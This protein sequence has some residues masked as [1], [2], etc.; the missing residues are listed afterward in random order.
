MANPPV[1]G[2]DDGSKQY[3]VEGTSDNATGVRGIAGDYIYRIFR[4]PPP[5]PTKAGVWGEHLQ[6]GTGVLGES[7]EGAGVKGL[8]GNNDGVYGQSDAKQAIGV[9]GV[10]PASGA[11]GVKGENTSGAGIGVLGRCDNNYGVQGLG[12]VGV[13]GQ[14]T[15]IGVWAV[16][17]D[18]CDGLYATTQ[19]PTQNAI[20]G[21][22]A[23]DGNG[24]YLGMAGYFQGNV[25]IDGN[26]HKGGGGFKIDHPQDA[27]NQYLTHSFVESSER[28][29]V[30]DGTAKLDG[31]GEAEVRLPKWFGA[32]NENFRYQLTA[33]GGA[34][35]NLH[36]AREIRGGTFRIAGGKPKGKVCW[37]VTGVRN[38]RWAKANPLVVEQRKTRRERGRY[39]HPQLYGKG[40][41]RNAAWAAHPER[42]KWLS[43]ERKR[44]AEERKRAKRR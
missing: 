3:G 34:A 29:N 8:S 38:D 25:Q 43:A 26:L 44:M 41:N 37:Q 15:W 27:A 20:H 12:S 23:P 4:W 11:I 35:P 24:G 22:T 21:H 30:Y 39:V 40:D 19:G 10:T 42:E 18:D 31:R 6:D 16:G 2:Q 28:K 13:L 36:I 5:P 32:V 7:A 1:L 17:S 14:G 9:H 33:V